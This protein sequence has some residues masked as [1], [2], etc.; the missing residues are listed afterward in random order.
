MM[1]VAIILN[2]MNLGGI[3]RA[4]VPIMQKLSDYAEVTLILASNSGEL[5]YQVPTEVKQVII[6]IRRNR[7]VLSKYIM[8]HR[9]LKAL[10]FLCYSVFHG[11]ITKR[12]VKANAQCS[13]H[14]GYIVDTKFDCAIAFHGMNIDSLTRTLFNIDA[15]KKIAWIHGDHPFT[16]KH[17][18]DAREI[19]KQFD[20]LFFDSHICKNNFLRDFPDISVDMDIF[21]CLLNTAEIKTMSIYDIPQEFSPE[22]INI[23][24]VGRLS[25]EKGQDMIP[26]ILKRLSKY[27][28]RWYLIGDGHDRQRLEQLKITNGTSQMIFLGAMDNPYPYIK[29]CDIYVQPSYSE[30]YSLTAFEAATLGKP[31]VITDVAG[32]SELLVSGEDA[33]VVPTSPESI[34]DAISQLIENSALRHTLSI[35]VSQKEFSNYNEVGKLLDFIR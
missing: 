17:I 28:V 11:R 25:P 14:I 26:E 3:P 13:Q 10:S 24:T 22:Y 31:I 12:W 29:A 34:A 4:C 7:Y 8:E 9:Y 30:A 27:K 15:V 18:L 5:T 19:Y 33:L 35:N 1:K 32:A 20:K 16:D 23:L 2:E 21:Y 6:P